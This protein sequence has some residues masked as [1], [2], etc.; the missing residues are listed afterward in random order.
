MSKHGPSRDS[1]LAQRCC[2]QLRLR[3]RRPDRAS[4][5]L[6]VAVSWAVER[7]YSIRLGGCLYEPARRE[8]L[9]HAAVAV[10]EDQRLALSLLEIMQANSINLYELAHRWVAALRSGSHQRV[11]QTE[12]DQGNSA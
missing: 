7:D 3:V 9:N 6:A 5:T 4:R 12:S 10:Q 8:I 1:D 2:D 11:R